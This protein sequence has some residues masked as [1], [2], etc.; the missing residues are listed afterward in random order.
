MFLEALIRRIKSFDTFQ[1]F[2]FPASAKSLCCA[3][4]C[5]KVQFKM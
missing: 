4:P 1:E 2:A 5:E 3:V